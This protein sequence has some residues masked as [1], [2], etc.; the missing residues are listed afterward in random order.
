[1]SARLLRH[2]SERA[3]FLDRAGNTWPEGSNQRDAHALASNE[4]LLLLEWES[5]QPRKSA[6]GI[7]EVW[8][9]VVIIAVVMVFALGCRSVNPI[10]Q[11]TANIDPLSATNSKAR[12]NQSLQSAAVVAP[13]RMFLFTI[14]PPA[15]FT[16]LAGNIR[17]PVNQWVSIGTAY[18]SLPVSESVLDTITNPVPLGYHQHLGFTGSSVADG[19][20]LVVNTN[21]VADV[22]TN[23]TPDIPV[24]A[25]N[26]VYWAV[27]YNEAGPVTFSSPPSATIRADAVPVWDVSPPVCRAIAPAG[28][29][30]YISPR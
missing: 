12:F 3:S 8:N 22:G 9:A 20:W 30:L 14:D 13:G 1:M 2:I 6:F 7:M 15:N 16:L 18:G 17:W 19:Y 26:N 4:M 5:R 23:T 21:L 10:S 29:T 28:S 11:P 27:A 25:G 24:P